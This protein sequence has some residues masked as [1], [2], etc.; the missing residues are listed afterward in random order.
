MN[1]AG[2]TDLEEKVAARQSLTRADAERVAACVDLVS[3]GMLGEQARTARH[4][5]RV[6]FARICEIDGLTLPPDRGEA[7]EVRIVARAE[8]IDDARH[9]VRRAVTFAAGVPLTGF[10]VADLLEMVGGDHLALAD[11]ARALK[12]EGLEAVAETPIDRLGDAENGTEVVRALRHGGLAVWRAT[13]D[14]APPGRRLDLIEQTSKIQEQTGA[15]KA[16]AP[17]PRHDPPDQPSTGYDDVRTIVVARLVCGNVPSIQV[18]WKLYG[19]KLAQVAIA[20]GADDIDG[21]AS[22]DASALGQRRSPRA[23]IERQIRAA[24]AEPVERDG[25]YET[26]S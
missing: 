8:S 26:R 4:G 20:Y 10:S 12:Q 24:F 25:R 11:L 22:T 1:I 9:R 7:G 13:I 16:F 15:F 5:Q 19:P 3:V 21:V 14:D 17:L 2:L 23:D 18:D 6:T